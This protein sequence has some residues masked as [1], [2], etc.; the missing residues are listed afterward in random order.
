MATKRSGQALMEMAIG[1]LGL[2][3]VVSALCGFTLYI[4]RSLTLQNF[5]REDGSTNTKSDSV[6]VGEFAEKYITGESDMNIRERVV[7][8]QRIILK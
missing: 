7:M 5:L 6:E 3:L 1:M 4:D 8:P 2:A